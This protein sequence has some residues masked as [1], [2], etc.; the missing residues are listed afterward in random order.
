MD[1]SQAAGKNQ[2]ALGWKQ[3]IAM[4]VAAHRRRMMQEEAAL[5][6]EPEPVV[7]DTEERRRAAQIAALVAARYASAPSYQEMIAH[8]VEAAPVQAAVQQ[9]TVV[10]EPSALFVPEIDIAQPEIVKPKI[11]EA[12]TAVPPARMK[13]PSVSITSDT[14]LIATGPGPFA[15]EKQIADVGPLRIEMMADA[16]EMLAREM[17]PAHVIETPRELFAVRRVRP[18]LAEGVLSQHTDGQLRIFEVEPD[19]I[20]TTPELPMQEAIRLEPVPIARELVE[21][22]EVEYPAATAVSSPEA[23]VEEKVPGAPPMVRPGMRECERAATIVVETASLELRLMSMLVDF[24]VVSAMFLAGATLYLSS[25]AEGA[26]LPLKSLLLTGGA[27][28]LFLWL[29]YQMVCLAFGGATLGMRYARIALCTFDDENPSRKEMC[30]R[31]LAQVLS[32][33]PL[34]LGYLWACMDMDGLGWH[35]RMTHIYQRSY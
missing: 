3:D 31:V 29:G 30:V 2:N 32:L 23:E 19:Q 35:D 7:E 11:V 4:R 9:L 27:M 14:L 22:H 1:A 13:K 33:C 18:R 28:L 12:E 8:R 26:P 21:W 10:E 34:G 15:P 16:P 25:H 5:V 24:G 6:R 20:S 17:L